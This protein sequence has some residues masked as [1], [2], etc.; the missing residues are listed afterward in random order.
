[1]T[2]AQLGLQFQRYNVAMQNYRRVQ[3]PPTNLCCSPVYLTPHHFT[4]SQDP[5][6]L[7]KARELAAEWEAEGKCML[8]LLLHHTTKHQCDVTP[9]AHPPDADSGGARK[10]GKRKASKRA[11][12]ERQRRLQAE[13][14]DEVMAGVEIRGGYHKPG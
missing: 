14:L 7:R 5:G 9:V 8:L 13:A 3:L 4:S 10:G 12:K 11:D 6:L 1:M 2:A